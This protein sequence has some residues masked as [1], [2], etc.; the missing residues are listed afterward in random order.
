[1]DYSLIPLGAGVPQGCTASTINF[2]VGFQVILDYHSFLVGKVG[3]RIAKNLITVSKPTYA[4]DVGLKLPLVVK[5]RLFASRL[6]WI[7]HK[8]LSSKFPNVV[9]LLSKFSKTKMKLISR[10]FSRLPIRLMIH[11]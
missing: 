9:L 11:S 8:R 4:D 3:Y 10:N 7:G 5:N 6:V 2:N 1:L